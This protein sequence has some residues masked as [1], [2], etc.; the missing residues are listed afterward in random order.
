MSIAR[1]ALI[2]F[3]GGLALL[4]LFLFGPI[5][6]FFGI[7]FAAAGAA[8]WIGEGQ[9]MGEEDDHDYIRDLEERNAKLEKQ[10][11]DREEK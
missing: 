1:L 10:L 9:K 2:I 7:I 11:R 4:L 5:G 8:G 6:L 3:F